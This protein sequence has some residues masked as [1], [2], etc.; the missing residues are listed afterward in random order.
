M[1]AITVLV[2]TALL[3]TACTVVGVRSGT[4]QPRYDVVERLESSVELRRYGPRLAAETAVPATPNARNAAFRKLAG[5]I[6]GGNQGARKVAMTA[7]V[8]TRTAS[9]EGE[10]IA[11]TVP[12]A[13][14]A[15]GD[16]LVMRFFLPA[17]LTMATAPLPD[18]PSVRLV[19]VPAETLAVRAF[20]GS[21]TDARVAEE[22]ALLLDALEAAAITPAGSPE[23]FFYDPPWT[24]P[25]LRRNEVAMP[26][27]LPAADHE[28][29]ARSGG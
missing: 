9:S 25:A 17:A 23:A 1:R 29:A 24:V 18:D 3:T 6:F 4:E 26:V 22:T 10:R 28:G 21:P 5:Y 12:V 2:A 27:V 7:P 13:T 8:A 11:M 15:S 14:T 20:T 19:Q 16:E